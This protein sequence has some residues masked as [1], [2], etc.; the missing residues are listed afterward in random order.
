MVGVVG[1]SP[2]APTKQNPLC[3]AV[4]KG[5]TERL[6]L[7]VVLALPV[8]SAGSRANASIGT[9]GQVASGNQAVTTQLF[10]HVEERIVTG[11]ERREA[12][13]AALR[14]VRD[15]FNRTAEIGIAVPW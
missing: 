4:K 2:I 10:K 8:A 14:H 12:Q 11:L 9:K 5:S 6:T 15:N 7:F 13:L 3:W 1:S